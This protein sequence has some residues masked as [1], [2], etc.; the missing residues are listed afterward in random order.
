LY[1]LGFILNGFFLVVVI[2]VVFDGGDGGGSV[3]S[4]SFLLK[5]KIN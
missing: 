4:F 2:V 1:Y 5:Y 3:Y